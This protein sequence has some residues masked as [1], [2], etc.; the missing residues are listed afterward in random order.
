MK[1]W[2]KAWWLATLE[3]M[4]RGGAIGLIIY[5]FTAAD[6]NDQGG[7]VWNVDWFT[8]LGH[9]VGGVIITLLFC[10]VGQAVS[11]NGPAFTR[12]EQIDPREPPINA[13]APNRPGDPPIRN[14]R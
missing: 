12:V 11:K 13:P 3:R 6:F 10:L 8:A 9:F 1:F 5:L 14:I 4:I 7:N 2:S